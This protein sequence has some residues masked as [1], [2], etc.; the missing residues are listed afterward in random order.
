M[1]FVIDDQGLGEGRIYYAEIARVATRLA[2]N[3][4]KQSRQA[5]LVLSSM[6]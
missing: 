3:Y 5:V 1:D 6:R 4:K 2:N